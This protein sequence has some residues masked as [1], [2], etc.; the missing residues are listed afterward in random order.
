MNWNEKQLASLI[1]AL[2]L[3]ARTFVI[4][5]LTKTSSFSR[6]S[7]LHLCINS[8]RACKSPQ[9]L[10]E[11]SSEKPTKSFHAMCCWLACCHAWSFDIIS[12]TPGIVFIVSSAWITVWTC[13]ELMPSCFKSIS[14]KSNKSLAFS[15]R[16]LI[17]ISSACFTSWRLMPSLHCWSSPKSSPSRSK[18]TAF[19]PVEKFP[20]VSKHLWNIGRSLVEVVAVR[21]ISSQM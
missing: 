7:L 8:V 9:S 21:R 18:F 17:P 6:G 14:P 4:W 10:R 5:N 15:R 11:H 16:I 3:H 20:R 2:R 12:W 19:L 1:K 13:F